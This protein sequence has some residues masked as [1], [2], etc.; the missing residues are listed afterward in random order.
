MTCQNKCVKQI[1]NTQQHKFNFNRGSQLSWKGK[2]NI[3]YVVPV[4]LL[5][6]R[7]ILVMK[8]SK[9]KE[10]DFASDKTK[11]CVVIFDINMK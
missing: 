11:I 3:L 5:I 7:I 2:P 6:A 8:K 4:I 1:K 10:R 9:Q